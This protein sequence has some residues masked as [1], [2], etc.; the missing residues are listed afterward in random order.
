ML[1]QRAE[2][3]RQSGWGVGCGVGAGGCSEGTTGENLLPREK[4]N[5]FI[6]KANGV[7]I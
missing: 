3:E 5:T 2:T 6:G 1:M 4:K 7:D